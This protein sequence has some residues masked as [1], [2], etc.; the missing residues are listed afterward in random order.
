MAFDLTEYAA[1]VRVTDGVY[2]APLQSHGEAGA[3]PELLNADD[4]AVVDGK[5]TFPMG[6]AEFASFVPALIDAGADFIGGCRG[7]TPE[8]IRAVRAAVDGGQ[9]R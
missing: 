4:P 8:H 2:G 7:A 6:P 5:T 3:C 9:A 1:T